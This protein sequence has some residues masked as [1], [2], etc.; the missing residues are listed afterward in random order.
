MINKALTNNLPKTIP[1]HRKRRVKEKTKKDTGK[2]CDFH[3]IPWHNTD[4]CRS[5]KSLVD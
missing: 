3:K 2:W 5:K 4:E 1:S